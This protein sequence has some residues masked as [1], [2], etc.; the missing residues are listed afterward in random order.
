MGV[1]RLFIYPFETTEFSVNLNVLGLIIISNWGMK[2]FC[3]LK[4]NKRLALGLFILLQCNVI[5]IIVTSN[6]TDFPILY[7]EKILLNTFIIS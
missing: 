2:S 4:E 5:N 1:A 6:S 3:A 7:I